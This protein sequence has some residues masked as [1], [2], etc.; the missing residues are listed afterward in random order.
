MPP[1]VRD[2]WRSASEEERVSAHRRAV[3]ILQAWLGKLS[4]LEAAK[5]LEM[6][7]LRFWQLSQ[8]AV[9]GMVAGCLRQPRARRGRPSACERTPRASHLERRIRGLEEDL[10]GA[11]RLIEILKE[12][13]G[14]R[15]RTSG[16]TGDAESPS[17]RAATDAPGDEHVD[18][19]AA[20]AGPARRGQGGRPRPRRQRAHALEV[21]AAGPDGRAGSEMGS[22]A[23]LGGGDAP[24]GGPR[25]AGT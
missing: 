19:R 11:R 14:N 4:R 3:V 12:L 13:P 23:A 21:E 25:E 17:R 8:Q 9:A 18:R 10:S 22:A 1:G 15:E 6:A 5:A 16:E 7:P 20:Q 24:R 2:L